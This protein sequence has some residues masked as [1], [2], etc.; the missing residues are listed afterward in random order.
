MHGHGLRRIPMRGRLIPFFLMSVL[1]LRAAPQQAEALYDET[2]VPRYT[3]PDPLVMRSGEKVRDAKMWTSRRRPEIL[4]IYE[5]EVFGR[6]PAR[7]ARLNYEVVSVDRQALGGK[8]VRK[9]VT[10]YFGDKTGPKMN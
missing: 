5:T 4:G 10:V 9:I 2:K 7:P 6:S 1:C 3:L 8:A